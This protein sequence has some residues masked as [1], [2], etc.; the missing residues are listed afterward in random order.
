[1]VTIAAARSEVGRFADWQPSNALFTSAPVRGLS[2]TY[3]T[4]I[5]EVLP[6]TRPFGELAAASNHNFGTIGDED[7][8]HASAD[9]ASPIGY[10]RN[11]FP[12][13]QRGFRLLALKR[14]GL[15]PHFQ[16]PQLGLALKVRTITHLPERFSKRSTNAN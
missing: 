6:V 9:P 15:V 14:E 13:W 16:F 4:R 12:E 5:T 2:A 10:N 3:L 11:S 7:P 8:G 1:M